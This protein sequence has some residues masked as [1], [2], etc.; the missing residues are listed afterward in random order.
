[1]SQLAPYGRETPR[2]S[3]L[4]WV[5][6]VSSVH[7]AAALYAGLV[8]A[9]GSVAGASVAGLGDPSCGSAC[10]AMAAVGIPVDVITRLP[11]LAASTVDD[12]F[13]ASIT[14]SLTAPVLRAAMVLSKARVAVPPPEHG[15][16]S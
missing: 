16:P 12:P 7:D 13:V 5:P 11:T 2:S 10:V 1:M 4:T 6:L 14:M 8:C 15:L 9:I 3:V